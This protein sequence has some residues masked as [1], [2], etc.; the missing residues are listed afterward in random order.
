ME[1]ADKLLGAAKSPDA[2]I[3]QVYLNMKEATDLPSSIVSDL[4][5]LKR[6]IPCVKIRRKFTLVGKSEEIPQRNLIRLDKLTLRLDPNKIESNWVYNGVGL[7]FSIP[8]PDD[9]KLPMTV[10]CLSYVIDQVNQRTDT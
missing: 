2:A 6:A 3:Y 9:E 4:L 5:L 7:T 8:V 1:A 10:E